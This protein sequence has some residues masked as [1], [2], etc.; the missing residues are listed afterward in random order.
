M[1]VRMLETVRSSSAAAAVLAG[2]VDRLLAAAATAVPSVE[3]EGVS[4][5]SL[6]GLEEE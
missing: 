2:A 1:F 5:K 6:E 4:L 3:E